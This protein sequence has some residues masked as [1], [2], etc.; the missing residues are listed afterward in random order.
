MTKI[1]VD[2]A[3]DCQG[4]LG[5]YDYFVPIQV[6]VAGRDF[7]D[8]IDIDSD[9]FYTI[10]PQSREFPKTAQ[11][12][13]QDFL[14]IFED[15]RRHGNELIYLPLSSALSGTYQSACIA[16]EMVEYDRIYIVDS[17]SA[18]H[19]IHMLAWYAASLV[20]D[21][22]PAREIAEKCEALRRRIRIYAGVD[23]LEY[24]C[25]GGRLSRASAAVG[26]VANIKPLI[27]VSEE[28]R[29]E[30]AGKAIGRMRAIQTIV[31]RAEAMGIDDHF[32]LW[33]LYTYGVENCEKLEEALEKHHHAPTG[34][35]QVG[36]TIGAHVGPEAYGIVF[37]AK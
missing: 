3:A 13:P 24:L 26:E 37:V 33:S 9:T 10:L 31:S 27:T 4:E 36:P 25:R 20:K 34:R 1:L 5:I 23:T 17:R 22:V 8:G 14:E 29:V 6:S 11:P 28:G 15:V 30:P 21:G 32:P 35:K 16:K 2:S 7:R 12:S 19:G 18:T